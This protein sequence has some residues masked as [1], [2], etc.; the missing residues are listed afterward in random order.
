MAKPAKNKI[1]WCDFTG[2]SKLV[3]ADSYYFRFQLLN[4]LHIQNLSNC[5][6]HYLCMTSQFPANFKLKFLAGFC[7]LPQLCARAREWSK[8]GCFACAF[9]ST[10]WMCVSMMCVCNFSLPKNSVSCWQI[11][12]MSYI[13][14]MQLLIIVPLFGALCIIRLSC[15]QES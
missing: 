11:S 6:M 15:I 12:W 10:L 9:L 7:H 13:P 2:F 5:C 3:S 1:S 8:K 14:S 4:C